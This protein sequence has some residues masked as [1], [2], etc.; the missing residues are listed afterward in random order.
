MIV[1]SSLLLSAGCTEENL[2]VLLKAR[3]SDVTFSKETRRYLDAFDVEELH[4]RL[5]NK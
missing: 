5:Q 1:I 3:Y 2:G 4:Q